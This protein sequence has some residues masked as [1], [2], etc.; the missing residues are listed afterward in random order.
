MDESV[1]SEAGL[2]AL[3]ECLITGARSVLIEGKSINF[4]SPDELIKIL[5]QVTRYL[6]GDTGIRTSVP[7]VTKGF[8]DVH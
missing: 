5:N 3:S 8:T 6:A 4:H 7:I 2:K 1:F